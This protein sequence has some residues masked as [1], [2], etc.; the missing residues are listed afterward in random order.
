MSI[1]E[2][3]EKIEELE[4]FIQLVDQYEPVTFE[5]QVVYLYVIHE[6]VTTVMGIVNE[7]GYRIGKRKVLTTD[8]SNI[9]RA[10][11]TDAMH[12]MAAGMFRTNRRRGAS[13]R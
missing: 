7:R 11:P 1:D 5:Q 2:A 12:E 6:N 10:R 9:L 3:K 13:K 8:I 4:Q